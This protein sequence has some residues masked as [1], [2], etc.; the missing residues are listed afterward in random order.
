LT[1]IVVLFYNE[2]YTYKYDVMTHE[3]TMSY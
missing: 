2:N 1:C 3:A